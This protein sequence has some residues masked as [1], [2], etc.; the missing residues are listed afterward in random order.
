MKYGIGRIQDVL[1]NTQL[2]CVTYCLIWDCVML[3]SFEI[4]LFCALYGIASYCM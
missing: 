2:D 4:I 3:H 1:R